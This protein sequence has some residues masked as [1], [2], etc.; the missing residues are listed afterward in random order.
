MAF[1]VL[2]LLV[3]VGL[4]PSPSPSPRPTPTPSPTAEPLHVNVRVAGNEQSPIHISRA[5][6]GNASNFRYAQCVWF[7]NIG[8]KVATDVDLSFVITNHG[9]ETEADFGHLDKGTFTPPTAI[10]QHC[11]YGPL[12]PKRVVKRMTNEVVRVKHVSFADGSDWRP[13]T[14][15][16][17]GYSNDGRPLAQPVPAGSGAG[18]EGLPPATSTTPLNGHLKYG[19]IFYQP[20]TFASGSAADRPSAQAARSEARAACNSHSGGLN[21][22]MLGI[23]FSAQRC[24]ALGVQSGNLEYGTG[25]SERDARAMVLGKIANG[26]VITVQCNSQ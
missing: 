6:L 26:Q 7:R 17:R 10:D 22:C 12:W 16:M 9:G 18:N 1:F 15:F 13:G 20:G 24:G 3:V 19:A 23:E 4:L 8:T 11:Y 5:S 21:D 14:T 2:M 25:D